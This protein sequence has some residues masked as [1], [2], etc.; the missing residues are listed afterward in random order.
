MWSPG[1]NPVPWSVTDVPPPIG[2]EVG[3]M[4]DSDSPASCVNL[5]S[6]WPFSLMVMLRGVGS[7][8]ALRA[9]N[10]SVPL[11][12]PNGGAIS[13]LNQYWLQSHVACQRVCC[14]AVT[15]NDALPPRPGTVT[16]AGVIS[17]WTA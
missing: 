17:R 15:V 7:G 16:S 10:E 4:L 14:C 11:P 6:C 13:G 2:P 12:V 3:E 1:S 5:T 9:A 8:L